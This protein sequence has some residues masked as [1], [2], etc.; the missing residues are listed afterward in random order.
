MRNEPRRLTTSV[1]RGNEP[2]TA[3]LKKVERAYRRTEPAAPPRATAR[4]SIREKLVGSRT[5][6]VEWKTKTN[7]FFGLTCRG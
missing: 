1:P 6:D 3:V 4:Y 7:R 5:S 2:G